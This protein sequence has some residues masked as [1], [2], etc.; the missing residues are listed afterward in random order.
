MPLRNKPD[1]RSQVISEVR[2]R[3]RQYQKTSFGHG[4][5]PGRTYEKL[6]REL[7]PVL[8]LSTRREN[9]FNFQLLLANLMVVEDRVSLLVPMHPTHWTGNR[10][11]R[12]TSGMPRIINCM[13]DAGYVGKRVMGRRAKQVTRIWCSLRLLK[14]FSS[15]PLPAYGPVELIVLR[16]ANGEPQDFAETEHTRTLA[17]D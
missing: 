13:H 4:L 11:R 15:L 8:H 16:D 17:S 10:Q 6:A 2:K 1:F 3:V 14:L 5:R 7:L 12:T 9:V